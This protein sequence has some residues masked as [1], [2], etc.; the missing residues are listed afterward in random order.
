M[1]LGE[2]WGKMGDSLVR[3]QCHGIGRSE[4]VGSQKGQCPRQVAGHPRVGARHGL[5]NDVSTAG[6]SPGSGRA[7]VLCGWGA[8]TTWLHS[9]VAGSWLLP[10]SPWF[11]ASV[12]FILKKSEYFQAVFTFVSHCLSS[13]FRLKSCL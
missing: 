2:T 4:E 8:A 1:R 12:C 13:P 9:L 11:H 5:V 7:C 6:F 3:G 10:L